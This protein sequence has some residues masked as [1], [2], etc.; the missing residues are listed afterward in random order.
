MSTNVD[1]GCVKQHETDNAV[2]VL[3]EDTGELVWFPLSQV[4]SMHF[5][6]K[7]KGSIVVTRWIA[8]QKGLA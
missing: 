6:G 8:E 3:I 4:V 2:Q 5:D 7:G 1:I